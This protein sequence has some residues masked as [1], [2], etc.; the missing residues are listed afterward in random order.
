MSRLIVRYQ[1]YFSLVL[2]RALHRN[3]VHD[4]ISSLE[5][6]F[7]TR[8][9]RRI[10]N[11]SDDEYDDSVPDKSVNVI[12]GFSCCFLSTGK[13]KPTARWG[14]KT[15]DPD[16]RI[17]NRLSLIDSRPALCAMQIR[18]AGLPKGIVTMYRP[19]GGK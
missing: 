13:G 7:S 6:F 8:Q 11:F 16:L 15:T 1:S 10:S 12:D 14:R 17:A 3:L 18:T 5:V 19:P 4:L 2:Y 9:R